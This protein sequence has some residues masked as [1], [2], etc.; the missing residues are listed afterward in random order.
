MLKRIGILRSSVGS[1][2]HFWRYASRTKASFLTLYKLFIF[3]GSLAEKLRF[4]ASKLEF[5]RKSRRK[6]LLLSFKAWFLKEVSQRSFLLEL[7]GFIFWRKSRR[8]ASFLSFKAWFLKEVSQESFAFELQ[9]FIF[10]GSLAEKFR[11]WASKL[12]SWR[13]KSRRKAS[14][15][16]FKASSRREAS[17]WR[18]KASFLE[19]QIHWVPNWMTCRSVVLHVMRFEIQWNWGSTALNSIDLRFKCFCCQ[20]IWA[21]THWDLAA[22]R[23]KWFEIQALLFCCQLVGA[24]SDLVVNWFEFQMIWLSI[25]LIWD[26]SVQ[27]IWDSNNDL[28]FK[29][30]ETQMISNATF[31]FS[32]FEIQWVWEWSVALNHFRTNWIPHLLPIGCL[33]LETSA[34]A[35]CGRFVIYLKN[36]PRAW[37]SL[38]VMQ[39]NFGKT[40]PTRW[41]LSP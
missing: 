8:K 40:G 11:F 30:C 37:K 9:S 24:S 10:E 26:S 4:W 27:V 25:I 1:T 18:F 22:L 3:E 28:R 31:R 35:S 5:W 2:C 7:Q 41:T 29:R 39:L 36:L 17:F 6:A 34:A 33:S 23:F 14:F 21:S 20:F 32:C 15:L 38:V 16:S 19:F 12:N 13:K